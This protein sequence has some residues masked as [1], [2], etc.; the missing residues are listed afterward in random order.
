[1]SNDIEDIHYGRRTSDIR[2]INELRGDMARIE[3]LFEKLDTSLDK[4][5]EVTSS[6][7]KMLAVHEER[8]L[9][10]KISQEESLRLMESRRQEMQS[11]IK[12][13]HSR[14]TTVSRELASDIS[15][16]ESRLTKTIEK[17]VG[18]LK[19]CVLENTSLVDE[20]KKEI[21]KRLHTLENWRWF[22]IGG[23]IVATSI[24][25]TIL[26]SFKFNQP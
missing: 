6:I 22:I 1:M 23:V 7:G 18:E 15:E 8:I 3:M 20:E 2:D 24:I 25:H 16:T 9:Q 26:D 10:L 19:T 13:L 14:I 11:D 17:H 4:M 21:L 12:E 5:G